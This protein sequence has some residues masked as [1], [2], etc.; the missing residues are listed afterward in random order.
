MV[1]LQQ[2]IT[3]YILV[4]VLTALGALAQGSLTSIQDTVYTSA[5]IPFNGS[6]VITWQGGT[7]TSGTTPF[8]TS[9]KISSGVLSVL[10]APST[11][12]TPVAYYQAVFNSSDG[13]STWTETWAVPPS[14]TP[15]TLSQIIVTNPSG[16]GSGGGSAS[17]QIPV[18][19]VSGLTSDLNAINASL[20][21]FNSVTQGLNL[22]IGNLTNTVNNL[23]ATVGSLAAGTTN[24]NFVDDE[25]PSGAINGSNLSFTLAHTPAQSTDLSLYLNGVL[26]MNGID[27][28]VSANTIAFASGEPPQTGDELLAYYRIPGAGASA[29]FADAETPAGAVDG[30]NTSFQLANSPNP[31]A[32]LKLFK[33]GALL[34]Q[35]IDYTLANQTITF[36]ST[37][38]TPDPGDE[39]IAS[40]RFMIPTLNTSVS[41][42]AVVPAQKGR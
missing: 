41:R 1:Q 14:A 26:Q 34:E 24:A 22:L 39:L 10:L 17:G 30:V 25:T 18:S 15:V 20:S 5:G 37:A 11:N 9:V 33:N 36:A 19:Q 8:N 35:N 42:G 28:S 6:V 27:Y 23:S 4:S 2:R 32:S 13:L 31:G 38:I 3:R 12:I 40:Y 16:S 29:S 7:S 21:T